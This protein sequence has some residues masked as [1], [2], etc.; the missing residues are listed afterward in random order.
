L[1]IG[2]Q[3]VIPLQLRLGEQNVIPL[4]L[5]LGEQNVIPLQLRLGEQN[6]IP[7]QLRLGEKNV[8]SLE[9][10]IIESSNRC[11]LELAMVIFHNSND[12]SQY[13]LGISTEKWWVRLFQNLHT[14]N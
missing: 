2:K 13:R 9:L 14:L 5:R 3:N 4:Q 12:D 10:V 11:G 8:I 1:T 7:L 6:V